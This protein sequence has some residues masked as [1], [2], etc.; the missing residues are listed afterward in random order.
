[1]IKSID[2]NDLSVTI[3]TQDQ[4]FAAPTT[5][6]N[7]LAKYANPF[8]FSLQVVQ[9]GQSIILGSQGVQIAQLDIPQAPADG[10][11]STGNLV[12]LN[13]AF[14]NVPLKSLNNAAYAALFA[15]V[16]L[17]SSLEI[18]LTGS[19]DV[20]ARTT[21]GDVPISNIPINVQSELKG[22]DSF[23]GIA[24]LSDVKVTGSGGDGGDQFIV[25]PLT[26]ILN[27]PSNVSLQTV[28]V[29]LPVVFNGV[30]IGRAAISVW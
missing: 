7:T 6:H 5:S 8:G 13:I 1:V 14:T 28:D 22:I 9:A 15:G 30:A 23:G 18:D 16:T 2:L 27:N 20:I 4:A 12:D 10:G 3:Q 19:A 29:A 24:Q 21:I 25:S 26:T 11:V 17:Q